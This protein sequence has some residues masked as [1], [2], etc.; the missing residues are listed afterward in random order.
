MYPN[1]TQREVAKRLRLSPFAINLWEA[2]KT[3]PSA[4][5]LSEIARWFAVTTDWLLGDDSQDAIKQ[6]YGEI[7][8]PYG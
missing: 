8:Y 4:G 2:G 5:T 7:F 6:L 3:E 1:V